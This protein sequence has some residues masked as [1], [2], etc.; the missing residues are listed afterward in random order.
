MSINDLEEVQTYSG[1]AQ[2][3]DCVR[4]AEEIVSQDE[5]ARFIRRTPGLQQLFLIQD[6][7]SKPGWDGRNAVP[8]SKTSLKNALIFL[9]SFP[10]E[11]SCPSLG[12]TPNGQVTLEWRQ[13]DGR[14]LSF[15]FNDEDQV[16]FIL[17]LRNGEKFWGEQSALLGYTD[18]F[19]DFLR[20]VA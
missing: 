14:L 18:L 4:E 13:R 20:K 12:A 3:Y 6:I 5:E 9:L 1:I 8:I 11:F 17:F 10:E 7:C 19:I 15:A 2:D 16:S